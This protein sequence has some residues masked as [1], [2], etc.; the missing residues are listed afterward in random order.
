[1]IR[2]NIARLQKAAQVEKKR[3]Y[4]QKKVKEVYKKCTNEKN[5]S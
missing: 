4:L 3:F 1:M 5:K 2:S